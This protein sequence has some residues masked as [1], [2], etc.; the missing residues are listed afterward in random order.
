MFFV[1]AGGGVGGGARAF[2]HP[3]SCPHPSLGSAGEARPLA[4]WRAGGG[5]GGGARAFLNPGSR[6]HP[7]LGSAGEL[8]AHPLFGGRLEEEW[9]MEPALF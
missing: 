8:R 2:L 1:A 7:S 9:G 6:P 3:G 4:W 5:V